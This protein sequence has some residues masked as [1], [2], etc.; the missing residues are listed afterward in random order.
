MTSRQQTIFGKDAVD[1]TFDD[2]VLFLFLPAGI[3]TFVNCWEVKWATFVQVRKYFLYY[4]VF[5]KAL[6]DFQFHSLKDIFTY[7][8]LTALFIIILT[9]FYQLSQGERK[10]CSP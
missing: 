4:K 3:L 7:A 9:G 5:C 2:I 6:M 10:C 8:K 1:W